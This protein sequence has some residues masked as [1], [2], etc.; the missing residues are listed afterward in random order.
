MMLVLYGISSLSIRIKAQL[1]SSMIKLGSIKAWVDNSITTDSFHQPCW[2]C[3]DE[4]ESI[5]LEVLLWGSFWDPRSMQ[6][7]LAKCQMQPPQ[8]GAPTQNPLRLSKLVTN[9]SGTRICN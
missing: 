4:F 7:P 3:V 6:D 9:N 5:Y 8:R 2:R 1:P